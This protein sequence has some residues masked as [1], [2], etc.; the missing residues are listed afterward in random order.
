M[1]NHL[2]IIAC[3]YSLGVPITQ[4]PD[5]EHQDEQAP[6]EKEDFRQEE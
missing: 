6:G 1:P 4:P 3:P 2:W 5:Y